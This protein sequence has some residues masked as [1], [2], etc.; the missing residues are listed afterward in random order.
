LPQ[1]QSLAKH[2][3]GASCLARRESPA[4]VVEESF[5]AVGVHTLRI[6]HEFV[7]CR[8][9]R[10]QAGSI[11]VELVPQLRHVHLDRVRRSWGRPLTPHV[12]DQLV[13]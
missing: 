13:D 3:R 4:A 2:G 12:V 9:S 5:E 7:A 10:D 1:R 11:R 6:D 8:S